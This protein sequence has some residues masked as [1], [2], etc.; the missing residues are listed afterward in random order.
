MKI[1]NISIIIMISRKVILFK[2]MIAKTLVMLITTISMTRMLTLTLY[3]PSQP[4]DQMVYIY[5][6]ASTQQTERLTLK[7]LIPST[8]SLCLLAGHK[9]SGLQ[10]EKHS[11]VRDCMMF[12]L[13]TNEIFY[14][15]KLFLLLTYYLTIMSQP[16]INHCLEESISRKQYSTLVLKLS[17]T[18]VLTC[19]TEPVPLALIS[20]IANT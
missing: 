7:N 14:N 15:L 2:W 13:K 20:S 18:S 5:L 6:C 3:M 1:T 9:E 19:N 4:Q 10:E 8:T 16:I 11:N 12:W 17:F